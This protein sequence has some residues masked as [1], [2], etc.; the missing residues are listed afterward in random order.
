MLRQESQTKKKRR[1]RKHI[2]QKKDPSHLS[3][4][5]QKVIADAEQYLIDNPSTPPS[6]SSINEDVIDEVI[7]SLLKVNKDNPPEPLPPKD[8]FDEI[9]DEIPEDEL[10]AIEEEDQKPMTASEAERQIDAL[11]E[12]EKKWEAHVR[13]ENKKQAYMQAIADEIVSER[14][15]NYCLYHRKGI[16]AQEQSD[17][18]RIQYLLEHIRRM[19]NQ[20]GLWS[21]AKNAYN[22]I[23]NNKILSN[24]DK[25]QQLIFLANSIKTRN[26][27]NKRSFIMR[28]LLR[29]ADLIHALIAAVDINKD[30]DEVMKIGNQL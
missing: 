22:K 7:E 4:H 30:I 28:R 16:D 23:L 21:P 6:S 13:M 27:Q 12:D 17:N 18:A 29:K 14:Y 15:I 11:I 20:L 9:L 8:F 2:I 26:L 24:Y 25:V 5:D 19:V 1:T 3:E 10:A